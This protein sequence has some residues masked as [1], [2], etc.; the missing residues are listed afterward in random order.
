MLSVPDLGLLGTVSCAGLRGSAAVGFSP[1]PQYRSTQEV[2]QAEEAIEP[3]YMQT[4][5][6]HLCPVA[7]THGHMRMK[8]PLCAPSGKACG[9]LCKPDLGP[10]HKPYYSCLQHQLEAKEVVQCASAP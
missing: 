8:I 9:W 6:N 2:Q 7:P 5:T 4:I 1:L 3:R 10:L